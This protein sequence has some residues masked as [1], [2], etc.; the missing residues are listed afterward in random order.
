[1]AVK[2]IVRVGLAYSKCFTNPAFHDFLPT[3]CSG[4]QES[5]APRGNET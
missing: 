5:E 1:M 3:E 4:R 2:Y